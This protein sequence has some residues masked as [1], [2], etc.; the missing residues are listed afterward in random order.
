MKGRWIPSS[1]DLVY[2]PSQVNLKRV[3]IGPTGISS[4]TEYLTLDAPATML[5]SESSPDTVEVIY[6]GSKWAI[7]PAFAYRVR[8][9]ST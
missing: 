6:R 1:G 8:E 4:V 7:E 5:V 2:V 3:V 9:E